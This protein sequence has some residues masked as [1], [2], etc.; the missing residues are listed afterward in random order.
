M[1]R[2]LSRVRRQPALLL[3]GILHSGLALATPH[4]TFDPSLLYGT[5]LSAQVLERLNQ[6]HALLAGVYSLELHVNGH[7]IT[8]QDIRVAETAPGTMQ[9]CLTPALWRRVGVKEDS[10]QALDDECPAL[11][12]Q[13]PGSSFKLDVSTLR[14]LLSVPQHLM[15]R[16][17]RHAVNIDELDAGHP[18]LFVNYM[19]NA[20]HAERD[21]KMGGRH[22]DTAYLSLNGGVNFGLWQYRQQG[23]LSLGNQ[24][25]PHWQNLRSY[26]QRPLPRLMGGS[27][28]TLGELYTSGHFFSGLA[29]HGLSLTSDERLLGERQRGF[30][31]VVRGVAGSNAKVSIRQKGREIYQTTVAPGAFVIDDLAP[32]NYDGDLEVTVEEADGTVN[33]F[34]VPFAALPESLRPGHVHY[35]FVLGRTRNSVDNSVFADLNYRLGVSN[36]ISAG[37]GVRVAVG[38]QALAADA[39]HLSR[40]GA[41]AL[42]VSHSR[43]S[44]PGHRTHTGWRAGLSYS[45][46]FAPTATHLA[47]AAYRYSTPGYRDLGD[48]LGER[49]SLQGGSGWHSSSYR[50]RSRLDVSLNQTLGEYGYLFVSGSTQDWH[51]SHQHERQWQLGY[52]TMLVRRVSLSLALMRQYTA[53][54]LADGTQPYQRETSM[55]LSLSL[56]LDGNTF[57]SGYSHSRGGGQYDADLSG[58]VERT[59][60]HLGVSHTR[61]NVWHASLHQRQANAS[62]GINASLGPQHWQVAGNVQGALALHGGGVTLGPWLGDTFALVEAKGAKG[63]R[64]GGSGQARIDRNGYALVPA[65]TPYRDNRIFLDP[66]DAAGHL[67]LEDAEQHSAPYPGAAVKLTFRARLGQALLIHIDAPEGQILPPGTEALD[68]QGRSVGMLGQGNWLYLRS[69]ST[70][71]QLQL[72]WGEGEREHCRLDYDAGDAP[73]TPLLRLQAACVTPRGSA[74]AHALVKVQ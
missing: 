12:A 9:P 13:V 66:Q 58:S 41:I 42:T 53:R 40:A 34:K 24:R 63:A 43:A 54:A 6:P 11:D 29:Y 7:L 64:V 27:Q 48:V 69:E 2:A 4:W 37:A 71:G 19:G 52:S 38:Y 25:S 22:E 10:I 21:G 17:S 47:I 8:R 74:A 51:H 28:L 18:L 72:R 49:F 55:S 36:R 35:N 14:L 61:E 68:T 5:G 44:M 23:S 16:T 45:R 73:E 62:L 20:W 1:P 65:L 56:P 60:Y 33:T 50:Q 70:H 26:L 57:S 31:P 39:V 15:Q 3:L 59:S 30:A 67:E 46:T 32:T